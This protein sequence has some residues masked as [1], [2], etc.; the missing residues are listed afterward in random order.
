MPAVNK[1]TSAENPVSSLNGTEL[2]RIV[3]SGANFKATTAQMAALGPQAIATTKGDLIVGT[4]TTPARLPV[5][6]DGQ[7]PY[8]DSTQTTGIRWGA[9][10]VPATDL[11]STSDATK[12]AGQVGF[13]S[14]LSY[15]TGTIGRWLKD[16]STSVGSS[17]V[18][19]IQ[20]ITGAVLRTVQDKLRETKSIADFGVIPDGGIADQSANFQIAINQAIAGKFRL[21]AP[22]GKYRF[23]SPIS[24]LLPSSGSELFWLSGDLNG[25]TFIFDNT[26]DFF[27]LDGAIGYLDMGPRVRISGIG[28]ETPGATPTSL[29]RNKLAIN[30]QLDHLHFNGTNVSE[31]HIVNVKGYGLELSYSVFRFVTGNGVKLMAAPADT[32]YSYVVG[33]KKCDFSSVNGTCIY[34][35]GCAT[36]LVSH[37]IMQQ[38]MRG[39]LFDC[40]ATSNYT[41][42]AV[43]DSCWFEQNVTADISAPSSPDYWAEFTL[44]SC[45]F[46]FRSATMGGPATLPA[47]IELGVRSRLNILATT[48]F[49]GVICNITGS[50]GAAA[51]LFDAVGFVQVGTFA[52]SEYSRT[53]ARAPYFTSDDGTTAAITSGVATTIKTL[54]SDSTSYNQ[55]ILVTATIA[56]GGPAAYQSVGLLT[57]SGLTWRLTV[58]QAA[59]NLAFSLSGAALQ[60]TQTSGAAASVTWTMTRIS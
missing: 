33:I 16:L 24:V 46:G 32:K 37:T 29:I 34:V 41:F 40:A 43:F 47:L 8:A 6:T 4:A 56:S 60:V 54:P 27:T 26:G 38:S 7:Q 52:W 45:Q 15:A 39:V 57:S 36:L 53:R 49:G 55:C 28:F 11:A 31:A 51:T 25:T 20:A 3:Q 18:G 30:V 2:V 12:G 44:R 1:T 17:V 42:N 21:H 14:S 10:G 58:L 22:A 48:V 13:L 23:N 5:G 35:E 59:T 50:N 9:A 19:F